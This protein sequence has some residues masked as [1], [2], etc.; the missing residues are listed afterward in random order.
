MDEVKIHFSSSP[1]SFNGIFVLW[2]RNFIHFKKN[3]LHSFFWI[4]L[5]PIFFLLAIGYGLGFY[6]G[7][8][9]GMSYLRYFAPALLAISALLI[10][11]LGS[12]HACYDK[13]HRQGLYQGILLTPTSVLE[14]TFGEILW[15]LTQSFFGI[16]PLFFIFYFQNIISVS[17]TSLLLSIFILLLLCWIFS[18]LGLYLSFSVPS[19]SHFTYYYSGLLLPLAFF[20]ETYFPLSEWPKLV[21]MV[22]YVFPVTHATIHLRE[23]L[24]KNHFSSF[25]LVSLSV[26]IFYAFILTLLSFKKI[27]KKLNHSMPS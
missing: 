13:F 1:F 26:L 8:I 15:G 22:S 2:K 14:I 3:F 21:Q 12:S 23:I 17:F 19:E 27:N 7:K 10:S 6:V 25:I 9:E 5:E 24:I 20:S 18:A 16:L 4:V 11:F